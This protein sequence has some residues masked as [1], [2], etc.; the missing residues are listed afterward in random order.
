MLSRSI[1]RL[2]RVI[3]MLVSDRQMEGFQTAGMGTLTDI[4][5]KR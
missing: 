1:N 4:S 3:P 5:L 2:L